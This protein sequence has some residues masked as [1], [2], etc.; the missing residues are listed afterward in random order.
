M[1]REK[2][3]ISKAVQNGKTIINGRGGEVREKSITL[4]RLGRPV[5]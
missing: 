2:P 3:G 5:S 1:F 4:A